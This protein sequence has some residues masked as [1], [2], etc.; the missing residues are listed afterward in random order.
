MGW[1]VHLRCMIQADIRRARGRL[2]RL[3]PTAG[4]GRVPVPA[5]PLAL[6]V[7][8]AASL[9]ACADT[10]DRE[11][12]DPRVI[13]DVALRAAFD[14]LRLRPEGLVIVDRFIALERFLGYTEPGPAALFTAL[15]AQFPGSRV[16]THDA[17]AREPAPG[18]TLVYVSRLAYTTPSEVALAVMT[19]H[20]GQGDNVFGD[21]YRM[22][23]TFDGR[24]WVPLRVVQEWVP[25]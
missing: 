1:A 19:Y 22:R 3:L 15:A 16:C 13:Y 4:V 12:Q 9:A 8:V 23:L 24:A 10:A 20:Q 11:T 18:E 17:C 2:L 21:G 25:E 14:S 5:T 6:L 7:V